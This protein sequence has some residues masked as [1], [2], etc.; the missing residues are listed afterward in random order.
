LDGINNKKMQNTFSE[1]AVGAKKKEHFLPVDI[2]R[3]LDLKTFLIACF[4]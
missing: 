2:N 3:Q 1:P 4:I